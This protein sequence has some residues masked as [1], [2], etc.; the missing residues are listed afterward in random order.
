[1]TGVINMNFNLG[2]DEVGYLVPISQW[3]RKRPYTY[4]YQ[5]APYGEIY[6]GNPEVSP[7]VHQTSLEV[8]HRLHQTLASILNR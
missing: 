6:V 1:M 4:D 3:D 5:E 8:L 7:L 2:M